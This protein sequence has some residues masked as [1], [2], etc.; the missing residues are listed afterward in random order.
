MKLYHTSI[1][2]GSIEMSPMT[3][4]G[5]VAES[6]KTILICVDSYDDFFIKGTV[7]HGLFSEG[8]AFVNLMQL[9]LIIENIIDDTGFP[10][11]TTE[12]R[13]FHSFQYE[14]KASD[15]T[16]GAFDFS[17]KKGKAA[18]FRLKILFRHN[19][20]WQGSVAWL[21]GNIEEPFRSALELLM[22][23]HSAMVD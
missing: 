18:T 9:L 4:R 19:A 14:E 6:L 5:S 22:L 23:V 15:S 11:A 1:I 16:D 8:A 21:E 12:K 7:Y 20:S 3:G 17:M 13:R 2:G 10:K